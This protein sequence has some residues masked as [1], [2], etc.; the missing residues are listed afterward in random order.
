MDLNKNEA[1]MEAVAHL[2]M[3]SGKLEDIDETLEVYSPNQNQELNGRVIE[4]MH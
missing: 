4:L 3:A 1:I 2:I